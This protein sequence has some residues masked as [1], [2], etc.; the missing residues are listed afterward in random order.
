MKTFFLGVIIFGGGIPLCAWADE[1]H[2]KN[3]DLLTGILQRETGR[4][5][6]FTSDNLGPITVSRNLI[7]RLVVVDTMPTDRPEESPKVEWVR[8]LEGQY[9]LN[10]GNTETESLGGKIYINRNRVKV[11]EWT[12][13]A[14]G[15]YGASDRKMNDRRYYG[16]GRYAWSFGPTRRWYHFT[17]LEGDHD[18]FANIRIRYVPA[19]GIGYWFSD[20]LPFKMLLESGLGVERTNYLTGAQ[21]TTEMIFAGRAYAEWRLLEKFTLSEEF[22]IYPVLSDP[23]QFRFISESQA[24]IPLYEG[25]SLKFSLIDEY[26]SNPGTATQKNDLRVESSVAYSF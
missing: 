4:E 14:K 5:V 16:L 3:G 23:G 11:D 22:T 7:E 13:S 20:E 2:F 6:V 18:R 19:T 1:I 24:K 17:K 15:Q 8:E 9:Q 26:K 12:I 25:L 10:R 21:N